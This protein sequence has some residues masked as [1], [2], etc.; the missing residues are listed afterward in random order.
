VFVLFCRYLY[1]IYLLNIF[2]Y[3]L[4]FSEKQSKEKV[5]F[6]YGYHPSQIAPYSLADSKRF[7]KIIFPAIR[8]VFQ[9]I[10]ITFLN[11]DLIIKLIIT[12]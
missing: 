2:T 7:I 1:I 11:H 4:Y 10:V 12:K 8:T 3:I 6:K 5:D 9:F